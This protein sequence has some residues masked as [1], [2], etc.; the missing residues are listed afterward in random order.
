MEFL[1]HQKSQRLFSV[2]KKNIIPIALIFSIFFIPAAKAS[3]LELM[4]ESSEFWTV[5]TFL[6]FF[7]LVY[8]ALKK[9]LFGEEKAIASVVSIIISGFITSFFVPYAQTLM[10]NYD[11]AKY[12]FGAGVILGMI[13]IVQLL[14]K[15]G[16]LKLKWLAIVYFIVWCVYAFN[17]INLQILY[18]LRN[19]MPAWI[20]NIINLLAVFAGLTLIS[21]LW[22]AFNTLRRG[23]TPEER[24][25][26]AKTK[27]AEA[28]ARKNESE[29]KSAEAKAKAER[30]EAEKLALQREKE[31]DFQRK[32]QDRY[33]KKLR[34][35]RELKE[36]RERID[37]KKKDLE[38][39]G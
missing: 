9:V 3:F 24:T 4:F 1:R 10:T 8:F 11:I 27:A 5:A 30:A 14:L 12:I 34:R 26:W 21:S 31:A 28:E 15:L 33:L 19:S 7:A 38:K 22:G 13:L 2:E 6:F 35:E 37:S 36:L 39:R 23:K 16:S 25:E 17:P 20:A 29:A 18:D 32:V